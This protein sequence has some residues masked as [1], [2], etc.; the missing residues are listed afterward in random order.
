[1]GGETES[2][3]PKPSRT[4]RPAGLEALLYNDE[5]F[6][7]LR[8]RL[9][10]PDDFIN[11]GWSIDGLTKGSG[12]GGT[13]MIFLGSEY[14]VKEMSQG[15]HNTML[16]VTKS[17]IEHVSATDDTFLTMVLAHFEDP[18]TNKKYFAMGNQVGKGPFTSLYDLKGCAD[19][20]ML[21]HEGKPVKSVHK[22]IWNLSMWFGKCMW[23]EERRLYYS[24]KQAAAHIDLSVTAEQR[25]L[26]L[27]KIQRDTEWLGKHRLM[28]YSLLVGICHGPAGFASPS[29]GLR[30]CMVQRNK[31]GDGDVA[32]YIGIIDFLQKWTNGKKCARVIKVAE[33]NKATIPPLPYGRRFY[34]H[35]EESFTATAEAPIPPKSKPS[36]AAEDDAANYEIGKET[37]VDA[38]MSAELPF[39]A[40]KRDPPQ[41]QK[42]DKPGAMAADVGKLEPVPGKPGKVLL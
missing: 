1:M 26:A 24:C 41:S 2:A 6:A 3:P 27:R 19:D 4:I 18:A 10:V 5:L 23:S 39:P 15:D 37:S 13:P 16:E 8:K 7:T 14:V 28:D 36:P 17:Y 21:V 12:K 42:Q 31:Q 22:R 34:R 33:C 35:F 38:P 29:T 30:S 32:I 40:E 20:K 9:G 11:T 25:T